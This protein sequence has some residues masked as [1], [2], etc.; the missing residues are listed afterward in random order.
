[1]LCLREA[2]RPEKRLRHTPAFSIKKDDWQFYKK[3]YKNGKN[4]G[5]YVKEISIT[6]L[7]RS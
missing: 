7:F 2:E 3:N 1:M 6:V 5:K 4:F